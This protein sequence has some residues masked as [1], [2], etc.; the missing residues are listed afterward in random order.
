MKENKGLKILSNLDVILASIAL[1]VLIVL[2]SSGVIMRYVVG[3][4][5]TWLEEVQL[6]CMV[7]IVYCAAGAAFRTGNHVAIEMVVEMF[8]VKVQKIIGYIIDA[9]VLA[10]LAFLFI[11]GITFIN[12]LLE[13]GR[14]TSM[15]KIP[16]WFDYGILLVSCLSMM[17]NYIYANY[18]MEKEENDY[19]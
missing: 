1:I 9:I 16:Y 18:F 13:S 15:L 10:V 4:P 5:Y 2:T 14:S 6:F 3:Q 7:W 19:E 17:G 11:N 8:P 12:M